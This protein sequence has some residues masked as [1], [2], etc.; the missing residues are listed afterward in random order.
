M[1]R[2]WSARG[3]GV[4]DEP[5][6]VGR[7]RGGD[8]RAFDEFFGFFAPRLSS[9]A[10]RRSSLDCAPIEDVVQ[11]TMINAMRNL[12]G[13]RGSAPL[14]TWRAAARPLA[15]VIELTDFTRSAVRRV[16]TRLPP[17]YSR[18]LELRFGDDLCGR[19]IAR[20]LQLSEDAAQSLLSRA[21]RAFASAWSAYLARTAPS[22]ARQVGDKA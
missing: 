6:L 21:R 20:T 2:L 22:A 11:L 18:I 15:T 14:F 7:M 4:V 19:G 17:H 8:Q 1:Q 3:E 10:V 12:H 5:E 16:I 9:F 13:Y